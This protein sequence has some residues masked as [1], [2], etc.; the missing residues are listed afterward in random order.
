M[1]LLRMLGL[2]K[3]KETGKFHDFT[4]EVPGR[5]VTLVKHLDGGRVFLVGK[6][7]NINVGDMVLVKPPRGQ[8]GPTRFRVSTVQR[9]G[10][11]WRAYGATWP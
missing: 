8:K 10:D 6:D 2:S 4:I 7:R 11:S 5:E 9:K 3:S 1:S